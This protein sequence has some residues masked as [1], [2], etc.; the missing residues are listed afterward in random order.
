MK[1]KINSYYL[2]LLIVF[3]VIILILYGS[4]IR[5]N[6]KGGKSF[7]SISNIAVFFAE[8][9]SNLKKIFSDDDLKSIKNKNLSS[10]NFTKKKLNYL[11][12]VP[13][14]DFKKQFFVAEI[15]DPNTFEI[16]HTYSIDYKKTLL[17]F[18]INNEEFSNIPIDKNRKKFQIKAPVIFDDG[19]LVFHTSYSPLI[20]IDFCSNLEWINNEERFHHYISKE[21][22]QNIY[23]IS[24]MFPYSKFVLKYKKN[25]GLLEDAITLVDFES[26]KIRF[27]KSLFEIF[28]ENNLHSDSFFQ[29]LDP[30]HLN[31]IEVATFDSNFFNKGD[32][33][34]S[35]P[36]PA[37]PSI[38]HYRPIENKIIQ[39]LK[40]NFSWQHD[41]KIISENEIS[42]FNNNVYGKNNLYSEIL[43][44]NFKTKKYS[45]LYNKILEKEK[46]QTNTQG[47]HQFLK[48]GS[49]FV[50]ET[51][52]GRLIIIDKTGKKIWQYINKDKNKYSYKLAWSSVIE[53]SLMINKL[54]NKSLKKCY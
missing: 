5:H 3:F 26:G 40:G 54:K 35:I 11:V 21:S 29:Y 1:K 47:V 34:L 20:K 42:I 39:V 18:D 4:L 25:F 52:H 9:P 10:V 19:S 33:F 44:Y 22:N 30:F 45:K 38:I 17:K 8:V 15:L 12:L 2:Y 46:F 6:L 41:V 43:I 23:V 7:K 51:D 49:L 31:K 27:Q 14:F 37:I 32:L 13:R 16:L 50:E 53:D 36:G 24:S 28:N 48:D